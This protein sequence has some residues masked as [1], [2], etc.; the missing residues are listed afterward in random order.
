MLE[1]VEEEI[2]RKTFD[3]TFPAVFF[4]PGHLLPRLH[5][6]SDNPCTTALLPVPAQLTESF[7]GRKAGDGPEKM[8]QV[9]IQAAFDSPDTLASALDFL[10]RYAADTESQAAA[11]V[12]PKHRIAYPQA[13]DRGSDQMCVH[14]G[15][16]LQ[17]N[18]KMTRQ[19]LLYL[20][21]WQKPS[22]PFKASDGIFVQ[23]EAP[24][25]RKVWFIQLGQR[26]RQVLSELALLL[27]V[28]AVG[29]DM[30]TDLRAGKQCKSR[31]SLP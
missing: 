28:R 4:L 14:P 16:A 11:A 27:L 9:S 26:N 18:C 1:V 17:S 25:M 2:Q 23:L 19:S 6:Q 15:F 13:S 8:G 24:G 10:R 22:W 3:R 30:L 20:Q 31:T 12:V 5:Q 7:A 29:C 21:V